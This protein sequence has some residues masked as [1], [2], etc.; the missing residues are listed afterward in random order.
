MGTQV[1]VV[2]DSAIPGVG[3]KD[4]T[5]PVTH[6][7]LPVELLYMIGE[8]RKD[9]HDRPCHKYRA[10]SYGDFNA[11]LQV[12][13]KLHEILNPTYTG[14]LP[15]T[16]AGTTSCKVCAQQYLCRDCL[17]NEEVK[18]CRACRR[19]RL[20]FTS[21]DFEYEG[22]YSDDEPNA[23]LDE[24]EAKQRLAAMNL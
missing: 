24:G 21:K 18:K 22:E 10:H 16:L 23:K 20:F 1:A 2:E 4:I 3:W 9:P 12:N 6:L 15:V 14:E 13:C 8:K 11:F 17:A 5:M 19:P 7:S